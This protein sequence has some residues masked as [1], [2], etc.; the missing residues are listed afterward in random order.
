MKNTFDDKDFYGE[1]ARKLDEE[2]DLN[3]LELEILFR[4]LRGDD[5][6][7]ICV[8]YLFENES[9]LDGRI[10]PWLKRGLNDYF[11]FS[12]IWNINGV[13]GFKVEERN[14]QFEDKIKLLACSL[15]K[16]LDRERE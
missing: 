2:R 15:H 7:K 5:E 12:P 14:S 11:L 16:K 13:C 8:L 1:I 10:I 4:G 6:L 3:Q 9:V